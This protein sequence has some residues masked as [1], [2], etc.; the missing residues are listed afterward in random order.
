MQGE[1]ASAFRIADE[2]QIGFWDA[3][4]ISSASKN[5]TTRILSEDLKAKDSWDSRREP[6]CRYPLRRPENGYSS[7]SSARGDAGARKGT[8]RTFASARAQSKTVGPLA[9]PDSAFG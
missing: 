7:A 5:G 2:W 3:L 6:V 1:I 4:I 8:I 9:P